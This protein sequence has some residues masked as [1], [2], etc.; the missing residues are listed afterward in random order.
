M[1]AENTQEIDNPRLWR[2]GI[3]LT[4]QM[5][6]IARTSTVT[7]ASL[8]RSS[9]PLSGDNYLKSLEEAVYATPELLADYGR[10]YIVVRTDS[11]TVV[12]RTLDDAAAHLCCEGACLVDDDT[13]TDIIVDDAEMAKVGWTL[14][15][16]IAGFLART[17]RNAPLQSHITP[18]IRFFSRRTAIGNSAK[19][20]AHI[21]GTSLDIIVF[22]PDG[23]LIMAVTHRIDN[24]TD[25]LYFIMACAKEAGMDVIADEILL[26]G[27]T[28][29]RLS[30]IPLLSRYASRVMPIIFPSAALRNGRE[31]FKVPFPLIVLPLCE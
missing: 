28:D 3:E 1:T 8:R 29:R 12:P 6:H 15:S 18:L 2:L 5:L 7:D 22:G 27:D 30:L 14:P 16:D 4:P 24:D 11:F 23:K 19:L 26:C 10:T 25:A 9:I 17:F 13:P 21:D 31:A 20:F